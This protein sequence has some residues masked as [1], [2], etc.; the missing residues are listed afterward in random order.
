MKK[1]FCLLVIATSTAGTLLADEPYTEMLTAIHYSD[2]RAM[3]DSI[4]EY[5]L[6][7]NVVIRATAKWR[8][9]SAY[10][11]QGRRTQC[12]VYRDYHDQMLLE[13][14]QEW[15][16]DDHG[17]LCL[18]KCVEYDLQQNTHKTAYLYQY[19]FDDQDR[20]LSERRYWL[21]N[22]AWNL[23][24]SLVYTYD[25]PNHTW[26][27]EEYLQRYAPQRFVHLCDESQQDTLI[28]KYTWDETANDW[29][30][31]GRT[32]FTLCQYGVTCELEQY[33][34]Y[35][36]WVNSMKTDCVFHGSAYYYTITKSTYMVYDDYYPDSGFWLDMPYVYNYKRSDE[37]LR[38]W[39]ETEGYE[40]DDTWQY[41]A[42]GRLIMHKYKST[43]HSST[44]KKYVYDE[45]GNLVS[46]TSYDTMM[47]DE[48]ESITRHDYTYDDRGAILAD[49]T[50]VE[51]FYT[52]LHRQQTISYEYDDTVPASTVAHCPSPYYKLLKTTVTDSKG[53][54][55]TITYDY[56]PFSASQGIPAIT[57]PASN[58]TATAYDLQG[59]RVA[60]GSTHRIQILDGRKILIP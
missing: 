9:E 36:R 60:A 13:K 26:T 1:I 32:V 18:Q 41:D 27:C 53:A 19:A 51:D 55:S 3:E 47:G 44:T 2:N 45:W 10:D 30:L 35:D 31:S 22:G 4:F 43:S 11:R 54:I 28:H 34:A 20:P 6:H 21:G 8:E 39:G 46:T 59:R 33:L 57:I 12:N 42:Q 14:E 17:N 25:D 49:E 38:I 15:A 37:S 58:R 7:G 29:L 56:A 23:A 40:F 5:D 16:Y 52:A 48:P 50:W 24:D